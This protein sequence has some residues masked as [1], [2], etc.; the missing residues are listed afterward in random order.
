M[1][2]KVAVTTTFELEVPDEDLVR[3]YGTEDRQACA[4]IESRNTSDELLK[5]AQEIGAPVFS[6]HTV[7]VV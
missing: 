1:R 2:L 3:V 4:R 7:E 6:R 5:A